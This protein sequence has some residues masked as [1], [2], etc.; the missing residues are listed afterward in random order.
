M[1]KP[2]MRGARRS[3]GQQLTEFT[4]L[5]A[6][7]LVGTLSII[8]FAPDMLGALTIYLRGFYVILGYPLG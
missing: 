8:H 7:L 3:R 1:K 4:L 6:A 2:M 5:S